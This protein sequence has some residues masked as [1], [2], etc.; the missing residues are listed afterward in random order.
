[1]AIFSVSA[2][3][4]DDK[5]VA[6]AGATI[7]AFVAERANAPEGLQ[8]ALR[9]LRS[10]FMELRLDSSAASAILADLDRRMDFRDPKCPQ[11]NE[12]CEPWT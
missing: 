5:A 9:R 4:N 6:R 2:L 12:G 8:R 11:T 3:A 7:D 1:M 10:A